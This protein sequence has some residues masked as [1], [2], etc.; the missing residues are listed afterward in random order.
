MFVPPGQSVN[1]VKFLRNQIFC[2]A[3]G[4]KN[5]ECL[6]QSAHP[7]YI[8]RC[9]SGYV[10]TLTI[11]AENM[12]VYE[13]GSTW[14]CQ[15]VFN[16]SFRSTDVVLKIASKIYIIHIYEITEQDNLCHLF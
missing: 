10:Y 16:Y 5:N 14:S 1:A 2:G 9:R 6:T 15:N 3:I 11:P 12:T 13:Q 8:Y 4:Y 7:E